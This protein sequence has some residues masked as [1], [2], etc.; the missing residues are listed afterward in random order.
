MFPFSGHLDQLHASCRMPARGTRQGMST[1]LAFVGVYTVADF[2]LQVAR[3]PLN[4]FKLTSNVLPQRQKTLGIVLLRLNESC[5]AILQTAFHLHWQCYETQ[6]LG[7]SHP[8]PG[9]TYIR[10]FLLDWR[11]IAVASTYLFFGPELS[12]LVCHPG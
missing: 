3:A 12:A 7:N 4:R 6:L 5:D 1:V 9:R 8:S 2:G 10:N 11:P